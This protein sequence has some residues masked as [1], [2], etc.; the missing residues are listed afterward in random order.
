MDT[1]HRCQTV[2]KMIRA[3]S[4]RLRNS[5]GRLYRCLQSFRRFHMSTMSKR[6][7]I[8]KLATAAPRLQAKEGASE[9]SIVGG[10]MAGKS[11]CEA[12]TV[13]GSSSRSPLTSWPNESLKSLKSICYGWA[14]RRSCRK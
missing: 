2:D 4:R 5:G 13:V 9:E 14:M 8:L 6:W 10:T 7:T 3:N 12:P 1:L 11:V